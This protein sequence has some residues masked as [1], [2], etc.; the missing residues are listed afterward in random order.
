MKWI[1][2]QAKYVQVKPIEVLSQKQEN[3]CKQSISLTSSFGCKNSGNVEIF[4]NVF[5]SYFN[6]FIF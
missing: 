6:F 1:K 4:K 5:G 3:V 2:I